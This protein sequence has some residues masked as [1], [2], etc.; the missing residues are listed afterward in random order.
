MFIAVFSFFVLAVV[1]LCVVTVRWAMVRDA[2]RRRSL[3]DP[4][5]ED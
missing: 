1:V 5:R 2:Q 4:S 3:E